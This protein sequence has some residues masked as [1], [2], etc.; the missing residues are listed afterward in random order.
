M[1]G[2]LPKLSARPKSLTHQRGDGNPPR[3]RQVKGSNP[4]VG[5]EGHQLDLPELIQESLE[6]PRALIARCRSAPHS[7]R[8]GCSR[9]MRSQIG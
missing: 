7:R 6:E 4:F 1:A 5:S 9:M 3:K 2:N 8:S